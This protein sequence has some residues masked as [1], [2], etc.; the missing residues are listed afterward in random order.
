MRDPPFF[1]R[2]PKL[3][4]GLSKHGMEQIGGKVGQRRQDE[5]SFGQTGVGN[6]EVWALIYQVA[7]KKKVDVDQ[8]GAVGKAGQASHPD[9]SLFQVNQQRFRF[10]TGFGFQCLVKEPGLLQKTPGSGLVNRG[11][12][13]D[14]DRIRKALHCQLQVG[15]PVA[16]VGA[17]SQVDGCHVCAQSRPDR[18]NEICQQPVS[19]RI[20]ARV[21]LDNAQARQYVQL[22]L[23]IGAGAVDA[24]QGGC[25]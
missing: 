25:R 20:R 22:E 10:E 1:R 12:A 5:T 15:R 11:Q 21:I 4:D 14:P 8:T 6:G 13:S 2:S 17:E 3:P 7:V 23:H 19:R 24:E 9:L 16:E 18:I